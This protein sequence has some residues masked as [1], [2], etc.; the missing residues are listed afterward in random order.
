MNSSKQNMHLRSYFIQLEDHPGETEL[1]SGAAK[2]PEE[3]E[4]RADRNIR[5]DF[6]KARQVADELD[7]NLDETMFTETAIDPLHETIALYTSY[8]N[9]Q[10]EHVFFDSLRSSSTHRHYRRTGHKETNAHKRASDYNFGKHENTQRRYPSNVFPGVIT[11]NGSTGSICR[12]AQL[13]AYRNFTGPASPTQESLRSF[14]SWRIRMHWY[15]YVSFPRA[16]GVLSFDAPI[17]EDTDLPLILGLRE[18]ESLNSRGMDQS[19]KYYQSV[20]NPAIFIYVA[21]IAYRSH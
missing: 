5:F 3:E 10:T 4:S 9:L 18:M 15:C 8:S 7:R 21:K 2:A 19:R 20:S 16:D 17:V 11:D 12:V 13:E 1:P 6:E 14:W